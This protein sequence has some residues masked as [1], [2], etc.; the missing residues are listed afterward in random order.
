MALA[1][2]IQE[3]KVVAEQHAKVPLEPHAR[4]RAPQLMRI[5]VR[6]QQA[7]EQRAK[8]VS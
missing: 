8:R 3:M 2:F 7:A 6:E 5:V 4:I 1:R